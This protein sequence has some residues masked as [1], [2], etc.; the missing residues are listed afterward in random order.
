MNLQEHD[1]YPGFTEFPHYRCLC[2]AEDGLEQGAVLKK[3]I[4]NLL[5]MQYHS[6]V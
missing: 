1:Y 4:Q 2:C 5:H 6:E 3:Q